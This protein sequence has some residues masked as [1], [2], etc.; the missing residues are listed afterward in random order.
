MPAMW[1][2]KRLDPIIEQR[3]QTPTSRID[4]LQLMMQVMTDKK[5]NVK[6]NSFLKTSLNKIK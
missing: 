5:I 6:E 4:V 1:L 2:L 3:Q